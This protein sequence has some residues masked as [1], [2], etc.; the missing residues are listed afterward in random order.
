M[1]PNK[2]V[3]TTPK[4]ASIYGSKPSMACQ[5]AITAPFAMAG[6]VVMKGIVGLGPPETV[7]VATDGLGAVPFDE[8]PMENLGDVPNIIPDVELRKRR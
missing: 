4:V 7:T 1:P 5:P 3:T 8:L 6:K 2:L